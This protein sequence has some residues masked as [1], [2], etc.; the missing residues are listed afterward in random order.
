MHPDELG[1]HY[2]TASKLTYD[3][4]TLDSANHEE[5]A[6]E[7]G[8]W[9]NHKFDCKSDGKKNRFDKGS[10]THD[11]RPLKG[12]R[13]IRSRFYKIDE[14]KLHSLRRMGVDLADLLRF[15]IPL[16]WKIA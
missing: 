16:E 8:F 12:V 14:Q 10:V 6:D 3:L 1:F 4:H 7:H 5:V 2:R 9:K 15:G 13:P 11:L